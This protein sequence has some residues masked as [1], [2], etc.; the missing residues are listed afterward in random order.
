MRAK[1]LAVVKRAAREDPLLGISL[2]TADKRDA[3]EGEA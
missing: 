1:I 3:L 2:S